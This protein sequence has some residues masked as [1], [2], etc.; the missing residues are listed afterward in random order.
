[1][2]CVGLRRCRRTRARPGPFHNGQKSGAGDGAGQIPAGPDQKSGAGDGPGQIPAGP[3]QKSGAADGA[4][5]IPP[6]P[7][8]KSGAAPQTQASLRRL[9]QRIIQA[10]T[11]ATPV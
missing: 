11:S 1:M 3:D 4:G 5:Q 6:G 9:R 8:H 7:D 10:E 2:M